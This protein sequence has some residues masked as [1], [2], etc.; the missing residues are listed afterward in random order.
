MVELRNPWGHSD[1]NPMS[2]RDFLDNTRGMIAT[3]KD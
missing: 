1:P 3:L 2:V